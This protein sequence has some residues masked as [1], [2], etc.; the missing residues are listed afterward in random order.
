MTSSREARELLAAELSNMPV[1]DLRDYRTLTVRTALRAIDKALSRTPSHEVVEALSRFESAVRVNENFQGCSDTLAL[2]SSD[3]SLKAARE[4]LLAALSPPL[5]SPQGEGDC[6][7]CRQNA[8]QHQRN[9]AYV[10]SRHDWNEGRSGYG[11]QCRR[12]GAIQSNLNPHEACPRAA[13]TTPN[14]ASEGQDHA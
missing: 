10:A 13:L 11:V 3:M 1:R 12:C 7:V 6:P 2:H 5:S 9:L 14:D 4:E 8:E